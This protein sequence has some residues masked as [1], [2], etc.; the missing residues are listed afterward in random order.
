MPAL[1]QEISMNAFDYE[2]DQLSDDELDTVSG[3]HIKMSDIHMDYNAQLDL[4]NTDPP[5]TRYA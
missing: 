5:P 2:A 4:R 1:Q 3:G